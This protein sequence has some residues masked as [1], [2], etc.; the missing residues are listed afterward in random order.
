MLQSTQFTHRSKFPSGNCVPAGTAARHT[1]W[2]AYTYFQIGI[3]TYLLH[4]WKFG[5]QK[6]F[7]I[8][9]SLSWKKYILYSRLMPLPY[10]LK[11]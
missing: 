8:I 4:Y 2:V 11:L 7:L 9:S 1:D 3:L 5:R 6:Q 10:F